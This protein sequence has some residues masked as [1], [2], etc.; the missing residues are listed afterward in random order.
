MQIERGTRTLRRLA[1]RA[2]LKR[3]AKRALS[4]LDSC[5][6]RNSG[7][8]RCRFN[9]SIPYFSTRQV[10]DL[11]ARGSNLLRRTFTNCCCEIVSDARSLS[12]ES[13]SVSISQ[14]SRSNLNRFPM[15]C[16]LGTSQMMSPSPRSRF[17]FAL[18]PPMASKNGL[19]TATAIFDPQ[20]R[21]VGALICSC[22][23]SRLALDDRQSGRR[24]ASG[25]GGAATWSSRRDWK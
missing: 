14:W 24:G 23:M 7:I 5:F 17:G 10:A 25:K 6:R 2:C 22:G 1:A 19:S 9:Q 15:R 3:S 12:L 8:M 21:M 4:M 11:G 16:S 18:G 20:R 13:S